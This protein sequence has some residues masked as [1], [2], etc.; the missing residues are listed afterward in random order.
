MCHVTA[1]HG[2]VVRAAGRTTPKGRPPGVLGLPER[3]GRRVQG[4]HPPGGDLSS[5]KAWVKSS[6]LAHTDPRRSLVLR[7]G[8]V[9]LSSFNCGTFSVA[10]SH[11]TTIGHGH[12]ASGGHLF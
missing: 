1:L 9:V 12:A 10:E 4:E 7:G 3:W 2:W 6:P 8:P 11:G 5:G